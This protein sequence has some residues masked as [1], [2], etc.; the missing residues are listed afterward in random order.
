MRD[1]TLCY[2]RL[3]R[4][5]SR[6]PKRLRWPSLGRGVV[7]C[8]GPRLTVTREQHWNAARARWSAK[9]LNSSA[10]AG[11]CLAGGRRRRLLWRRQ[12]VG[13][14]LED[15]SVLGEAGYRENA[16]HL[17]GSAV[18]RKSLAAGSHLIMGVDY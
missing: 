9:E 16:A 10:A 4:R 5:G 13:D 18:E 14:V 1:S 11:R 12:G 8:D 3:H 7:L 15:H 17:I 6:R 2:W